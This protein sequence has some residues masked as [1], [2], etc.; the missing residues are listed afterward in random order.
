[1]TR[2]FYQASTSAMQLIVRK[3]IMFSKGFWR[4]NGIYA[5]TTNAVLYNKTQNGFWAV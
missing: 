4:G 3:L 1:M 2:V 5:S